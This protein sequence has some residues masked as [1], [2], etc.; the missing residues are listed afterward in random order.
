M[1]FR[2]LRLLFL[3]GALIAVFA[4]IAP[5]S[6][7]DDDMA[8]G[9]GDDVAPT[10]PSIGADIPLAYFGPAPSSVQRELIG[11]YQLLKAGPVDVDAGTQT[12][13][14]YRGQMESGELVWYVV[15]DSDDEANATALG[16]NH[17][18]KLTYADVGNAV[19]PATLETDGTLTFARG[20]VDFSPEHAITPGEESPF[21][22]SDFQPG[23]VGDEAYSPLMKVINAGGYVY[24][25]PIIAFDV[26][27]ETLNAMCEGEADAS[28]VHDKVV[29]ICPDE[30]TV[31]L[32]LTPG[33]SFARPVLYHSFDANDP[34]AAA[35]EQVTLAPGLSDLAVG[36]DDSLFSSV[37]RIFAFTN[38]PTGTGNPQRQGF[39]SALSGEG[40]PLNI[41]GGIP[42]VATD[43]S[44][45][46]DLNVGTWTDEAVELGYRSRLIEEF[47]I[48]GMVEQGW[49]T[50][51]GGNPYGSTGIIVNCPIVHRFL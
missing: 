32:R 33:M 9:V 41:L 6:A 39:N 16:L 47:Q 46:W 25:A 5:A 31:T 26:D 11:P 13:P 7:Q 29:S 8:E 22:P 45:L 42:T 30:Q 20:T 24:N 4:L 40:S 43:Y 34:M 35:M 1:K 50:G 12:L 44:P 36:G 23:S 21:P 2:N 18:P 49:I 37:E 15:T 14:L 10:P 19:R 17:S 38:G 48:L 27:A 51:P 3:V 28:L